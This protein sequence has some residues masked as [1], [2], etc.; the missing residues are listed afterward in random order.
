MGRSSDLVVAQINPMDMF[1]K[2][3][4][5]MD[6]RKGFSAVCCETLGLAIFDDARSAR[7]PLIKSIRA[8]LIGKGRSYVVAGR[9]LGASGKTSAGSTEEKAEPAAVLWWSLLS[10]RGLGRPCSLQCAAKPLASLARCRTTAT[11]LLLAAPVAPYMGD[12]VQMGWFLSAA[13]VPD[14]DAAIGG[15]RN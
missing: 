5:A 7:F 1:P 4:A 11:C 6:K 9:G 14:V 10:P 8:D 2:Q 15:S 13:D 3:Q 12:S